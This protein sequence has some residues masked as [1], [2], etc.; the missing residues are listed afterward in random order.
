MRL[1]VMAAGAV[2]GYYGARMA[3]AGHDVAFLARGAHGEAI[4]REGLKLE[5][6]LGDLHLKNV[7]VTDDSKRVGQVDVVLFA[8]KLWDTESAGEQTRPLVGRDT[9]V[10]TLQ[11]GVDSVERLAPILGDDVTIGGV[12]YVAAN[13]A[14]PGLIRQTGTAAKIHCGRVDGRRD[15]L[16]AGY[17]QQMKSAGIDITLTDH[18]LFEI[19]KKFVVLSGTSAIT[20]S[21]RQPLG[22]VRDD[23]DMRALFFRL[24]HETMSVGHAAGVRFPPEFPAELERLVASFPPTMKASMANDLEAGNRLELD[25]L[26]GKVVALGRKHGVPTP[27][28]EAVYAILK[29]Y[30]MGRMPG[31]C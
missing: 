23:T 21:T 30:R 13:I 31:T 24:M 2:G 8:V 18:M 3:A 10:I 16:L 12:T 17:V 9:R 6:A 1:A 15:A 26:A 20:A 5:S 22:A 19:W 25:W 28:Q 4:R 27:A 29:P 11:N 14:R 7:Q